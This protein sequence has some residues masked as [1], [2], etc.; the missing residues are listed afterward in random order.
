MPCASAPNDARGYGGKDPA[1]LFAGRAQGK[2]DN[3]C[4]DI[5]DAHLRGVA[6]V[7]SADVDSDRSRDHYA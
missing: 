2:P 3:V 7:G 6:S 1:R 5:L 4:V